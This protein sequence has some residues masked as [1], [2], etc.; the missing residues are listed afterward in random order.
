MQF[1]RLSLLPR[2]LENNPCFLETQR[3]KKRTIQQDIRAYTIYNFARNMYNI[4]SDIGVL[5]IVKCL[6]YT[7]ALVYSYVKVNIA[8]FWFISKPCGLTC[9]YMVLYIHMLSMMSPQYLLTYRMVYRIA[10][11]NVMSPHGLE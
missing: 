1:M 6:G 4:H 10:L 9:R 2:F 5:H 8:G 7:L 11:R 3:E